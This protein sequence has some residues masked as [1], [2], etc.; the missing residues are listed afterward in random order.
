MVLRAR[1][2]PAVVCPED[3]SAQ[4]ELAL[5]LARLLRGDVAEAVDVLTAAVAELE[6]AD[7]RIGLVDAL[8]MLRGPNGPAAR[9]PA[10]TRRQREV[11]E[12]LAAGMANKA[13]ARHLGVEISTVKTYTNAIYR[14]L[15]VQ[16]RT[17]AIAAALRRGLV[18]L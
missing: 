10:L 13:I 9:E 11:L 15:G 18:R 8:T 4:A 6:P 16:S 1:L 7:L 3:R 17:Q 12:L 5:G 14:K 2:R